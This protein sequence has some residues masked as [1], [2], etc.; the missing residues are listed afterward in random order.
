[1]TFNWMDFINPHQS[2]PCVLMLGGS[3]WLTHIHAHACT[4]AYTLRHIDIYAQKKAKLN[5]QT[6]KKTE[7]HTHKW[8]TVSSCTN[9]YR[10]THALIY[11]QTY[12]LRARGYVRVRHTNTF[13][14][15]RRWTNKR[16]DMINK[17][18]VSFDR[19]ISKLL[20]WNRCC[21]VALWAWIHPV[22]TC[23]TTACVC[24]CA[25]LCA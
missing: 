24:L 10:C 19:L 21:C 3:E 14:R 22:Q 9:T 7:T 23:Q 1:M 6:C 12:T 2:L 15:G 8:H 18:K 11:Q 17:R 16:K 5:I 25:R 13:P 20:C 4:V